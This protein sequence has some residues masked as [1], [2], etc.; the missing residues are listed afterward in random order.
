MV[1]RCCLTL[2][3]AHGCH[4]HK[5]H[6]LLIFMSVVILLACCKL[7]QCVSL[8]IYWLGRY[9][10]WLQT[11]HHYN[12]FIHIDR[13]RYSHDG[14]AL[15]RY[16][17]LPA[18]LRQMTT[19]D[20]LLTS[21]YLLPAAEESQHSFH[22][23]SWLWLKKWTSALPIILLSC[24]VANDF[25]QFSIAILHHMKPRVERLLNPSQPFC[26]GHYLHES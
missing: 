5:E 21:V 22:S 4:Y 25:F 11:Q 17:Q 24:D 14:R 13:V 3:R 23:H 7:C 1:L 6:F 9:L 20:R 8:S 26:H 16:L 19:C 15:S 12:H 2:S 18:W 10:N